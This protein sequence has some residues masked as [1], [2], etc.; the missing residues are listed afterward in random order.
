MTDVHT[1]EDF[2]VLQ[3]ARGQDV[4][5][6]EL[7]SPPPSRKDAKRYKSYIP[8]LGSVDFQRNLPEAEQ[9]QEGMQAV[10][11][12]AEPGSRRGN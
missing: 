5:E 1:A 4:L 8:T 3:T 10:C 12:E 6:P 7:G 2:P 11:Q 9:R